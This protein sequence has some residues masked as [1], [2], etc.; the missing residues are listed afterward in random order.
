MP[1]ANMYQALHTTVIG[2][3]G[4]PLEIQIRTPDM[5]ELAE[6]GIAAHVIY[7]EGRGRPHGDP[8][9][10]KMTWLRQLLEAESRG[11][12]EAVPR[13]AQGRPVRGR[14]L[15]LHPE[16]G[17]QEPLGRLDPARLRLRRP[18]RR[19]PPLRRRQGQRQ[20]RPAPLPAR[21]GDIVEVLTAKQGR[22]PSRDWLKLVRTS[23]ARNK[24]RAWFQREGREDAERR[25]REQL[26]D[27]LREARPPAPEDR[28]LAAARR[29]DPGDGLPQGRRLLHRARPVKIST[30]VV[31]NK[32]MQRLKR[33]RGG[34]GGAGRGPAQGQ[35]RR[36]P[37][38]R[39]GD[40][41]RDQ[42]Q[43]RRGRRRPPRQVLPAGARATRSSATSPSAAASP[44]T[45]T[46]AAT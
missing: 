29:R 23:R 36:P 35:R 12:P 27:A 17:G 18:H 2:P 32:V 19:R 6:Y 15:R 43:G 25:G 34:R 24:I 39:G 3:E 26:A 33:G 30:K 41:L 9:R 46:T 7:K 4:R 5:H 8:E 38:N 40:Q 28:R 45:A 1:K 16:G 44:C 13:G 37:A 42:G 21:S 10:E 11:R 31:T 20:D 14:G 22:G